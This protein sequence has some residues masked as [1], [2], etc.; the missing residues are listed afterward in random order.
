[1][2]GLFISVLRACWTEDTREA[3]VC[4]VRLFQGPT[5]LYM[6]S[7]HD[8][9]GHGRI[10]AFSEELCRDQ[11]GT[12]AMYGVRINGLINNQFQHSGCEW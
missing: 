3:G 4:S 2:S 11:P 6:I 1:M 7:P 10:T 9:D 12:S 8:H 5:D